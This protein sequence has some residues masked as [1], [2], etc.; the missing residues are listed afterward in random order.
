MNNDKRWLWLAGLLSLLVLAYVAAD[1][2]TPGYRTYQTE[3]RALVEDR[4]GPE[5]AAAAPA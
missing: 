3:F 1:E 2:L 5:R 4:F